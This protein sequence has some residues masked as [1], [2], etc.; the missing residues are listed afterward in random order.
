MLGIIGWWLVWLILEGGIVLVSL[1]AERWRDKPRINRRA[2]NWK[3]TGERFVDPATGRLVQVFYN[4]DTG[5]RD[6]VTVDH[7]S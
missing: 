2:G 5:E 3:P 7:K 1:L 4:S 6:Y